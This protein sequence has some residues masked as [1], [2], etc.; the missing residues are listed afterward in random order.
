MGPT[1]G[2]KLSASA[3]VIVLVALVVLIVLFAIPPGGA[4]TLR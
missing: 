2:D 4:P 1:R 3:L